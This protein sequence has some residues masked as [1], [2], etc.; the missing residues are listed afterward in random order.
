MPL[1]PGLN[2]P[3]RRSKPFVGPR[4]FA[5]QQ[6]A[7]F[8]GRERTRHLVAGHCES[9]D[10]VLC[11]IRRRQK[12]ADQH[13]SDPQLEQRNFEVLPVGRVGGDLPDAMA[14]ENIFAFNL[15]VTLDQAN[16]DD[17]RFAQDA[18]ERFSDEPDLFPPAEGQARGKWI[19]VSHPGRDNTGQQHPGRGTRTARPTRCAPGCSSSTSSKKSSAPTQT[20]GRNEKTF[21]ANSQAQEDD[22]YLWVV[23]AMRE[24]YVAGLAPYEYLLEGVCA[25]AITCSAWSRPQRWMPCANRPKRGGATSH[26]ASPR[27][28]LT[29]CVQIRVTGQSKTQPG[30]FVEPVQLQVVCFQMFEKLLQEAA[31]RHSTR[32]PGGKRRCGQ[33]AGRLLRRY[34]PGCPG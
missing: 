2:T 20:S 11:P 5:Y 22:P 10:L 23:L 19:Y 33:C 3:R 34:H 21:S 26:L 27:H 6:R 17:S 28:W 24:D 9:A 4:T 8:F 29:I 12:L 31:A 7:L 16:A 15:M 13:P 32:R 1:V 14:V 25:H 18:A 30:Q